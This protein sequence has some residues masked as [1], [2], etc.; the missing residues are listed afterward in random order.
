MVVVLN[1]STACTQTANRFISLI[2]YVSQDPNKVFLLLGNVQHVS[3]FSIVIDS[4]DL[5]KTSLCPGKGQ[6]RH[7]RDT[8]FYKAGKN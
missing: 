3:L 4:R 1:F 2:K 6:Y 5:V 8:F 7:F